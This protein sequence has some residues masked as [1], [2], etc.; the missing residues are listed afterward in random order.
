[1]SRF[2]GKDA[3]AIEGRWSAIL[4]GHC[5]SCRVGEIFA[6]TFSMNPKCPECELLFDRE[7]GYFTGAMYISYAMA[8]PITA[9]IALTTS[10]IFPGWSFERVIGVAFAALLPLSPLFFRYSRILWIHFDRTVDP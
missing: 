9:A 5:P 3:P 1:M 6:G 10:Y 8:V 4:R 7:P 2:G